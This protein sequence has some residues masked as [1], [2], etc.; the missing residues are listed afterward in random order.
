MEQQR[1]VEFKQQLQDEIKGQRKVK[2]TRKRQVVKIEGRINKVE[3]TRKRQVKIEGQ[4]QQVVD[5]IKGYS[6]F[7]VK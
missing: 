3:F 1:K 2:I 7:E 6:Q 4:R 5:E